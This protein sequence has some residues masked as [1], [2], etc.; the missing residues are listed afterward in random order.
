ME[1]GLGLEYLSPFKPLGSLI[2]FIGILFT[3]TIFYIFLNLD[4]QSSDEKKRLMLQQNEREKRVNSLYPS[5]EIKD[6]EKS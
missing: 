2:I 5:K 4:K 6:T 3:I 1:Y